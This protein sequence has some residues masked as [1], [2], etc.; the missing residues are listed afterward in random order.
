MGRIK[1]QRETR[2]F[3]IALVIKTIKITTKK[4][5]K[6]FLGRDRDLSIYFGGG[7]GDQYYYYYYFY[8]LK[9]LF[10]EMGGGMNVK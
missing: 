2:N 1:T 4:A 6:I 7:G 3:S 8:S 9:K 5:H 10:E